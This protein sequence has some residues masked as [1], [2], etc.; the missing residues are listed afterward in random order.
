MKENDENIIVTTDKDKMDVDFI[1]H[2]LK[3]LYWAR[4]LTR[5]NLLGRIRNSISF[6]IFVENRQV[7]F[8]RVI[9]DYF[10]FAYLADVFIDEHER[11]K[12]YSKILLD[13]I[14]AYPDLKGI[15]WLLATKDL[16]GMYAKYGFTP[17][18]NPERFMGMNGWLPLSLFD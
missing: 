6:G 8:A 3:K 15:K 18:S 7:G 1:F 11:G 5:E 9:T 14:L 10:S 16:H 4:Q 13:Y 2:Q 12:G 17:V